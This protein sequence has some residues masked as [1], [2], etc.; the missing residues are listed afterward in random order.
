MLLARAIR[1]SFLRLPDA[2]MRFSARLRSSARAHS[3]FDSVAF[4]SFIR[5][6]RFAALHFAF[7]NF[8][9]LQHAKTIFLPVQVDL[10]APTKP[11]SCIGSSS[12]V[13]EHSGMCA[14]AQ[15]LLQSSSLIHDM[16]LPM[17]VSANCHTTLCTQMA[18]YRSCPF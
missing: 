4:L 2:F 5:V 18:H 14:R 15:Q 13:C 1:R 16:D 3:P 6:L 12:N 17:H 8:E 7:L 9:P 10:G 11:C